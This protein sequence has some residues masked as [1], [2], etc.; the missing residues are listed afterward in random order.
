MLMGFAMPVYAQ[1]DQQ[2][3][4]EDKELKKNYLYQWTDDKGVVYITDDLAKVPQV[5][6]DKALKLTQPKTE[7]VDQKRQ[8][9]QP[10]YRLGPDPRQQMLQGK[11]CGSSV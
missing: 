8:V 6:R 5:Y 2:A 11:P 9:Q 10:G 4:T 1:A 3:Q 7:D